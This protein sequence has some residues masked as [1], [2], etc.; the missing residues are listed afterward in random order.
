[1]RRAIAEA[2]FFFA[3]S[4][5]GWGAGASFTMAVPRGVRR[6]KGGPGSDRPVVFAGALAAVGAAGT[7]HG[8]LR[9]SRGSWA[10]LRWGACLLGNAG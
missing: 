6:E 4:A 9:D 10:R 7:T 8:W 5:V 3:M 1:M 2:G